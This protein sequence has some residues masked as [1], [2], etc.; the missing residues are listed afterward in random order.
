MAGIMVATAEAT[1]G[2]GADKSVSLEITDTGGASG[3]MGLAS[4]AGVQGQKENDRMSERT[5]R[6]EGRLVH[7]RVSKT[8]GSN[9]FTIVIGDRF[10]VKAEGDAD[11]NSLRSAVSSLD[12]QKL[13]SMKNVGVTR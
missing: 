8:G 7:Q 10:I 12:L 9:E 1:Y 6:I 5:E 13:E 3:L 11:I 4:W 2:D